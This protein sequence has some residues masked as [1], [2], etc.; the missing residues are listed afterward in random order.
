MERTAA[1]A[2]AH[3][4]LVYHPQAELLLSAGAN[5][6]AQDAHSHTPLLRA[7]EAGH[8]AMVEAL[9]KVA[10]TDLKVRLVCLLW[11]CSALTHTCAPCLLPPGQIWSKPFALVSTHTL[12]FYGD[13]HWCP[14]TCCGLCTGPFETK[15]SSLLS[16]C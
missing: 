6:N 14:D 13:H 4:P 8:S 9:A 15:T 7:A 5:V 3:R 16:L 11:W 10:N 12:P 2:R 1:Q